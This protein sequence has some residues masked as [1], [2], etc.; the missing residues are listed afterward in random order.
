MTRRTC[1][2]LW[3]VGVLTG[4]QAALAAPA[5]PEVRHYDLRLELFPETGRIEGDARITI[6]N[7]GPTPLTRVPFVLYRLFV[8][9]AVSDADDAP[10]AHE[11]SVRRFEDNER[12]Q[13]L[14]AGVTLRRPLDPGDSAVIRLRYAGPFLGAGEVWPYL[15]DRVSEEYS[16]IRPDAAGYPIVSGLDRL[17]VGPSR[18]FTAAVE[19]S[20]PDRFMVAGGG[21]RLPPM[22]D[23]GRTRHRFVV[24]SPTWRLDI[25]AAPFRMLHATGPG[26]T[27]HYLGA[28]S[29]AAN[30][31]LHAAHTATLTLRSWFGPPPADGG[32]TIIEVPEGWG[33]QAGDGYLL[34][35]GG[36]FR[37]PA[38]LPEVYHEVAHGWNAPARP[39]QQAARWFDE[40]F[41]S[42]FQALVMG[43]V[44]GVAARD[45]QMTR[46]RESFRRAVARDPAHGDTPIARY[47]EAGLGGLSYTKGAWSLHVL[48][49]ALGDTGFRHFIRTLLN[50]PP[51]G[52]A[53]FEHVV[54]LAEETLGD[55]ARR[56]A[57]DWLIGTMSSTLLVGPTSA[58]DLANRYR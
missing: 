52:G 25:A 56:W 4:G 43:D 12:H 45:S 32:F 16:L 57:E 49:L 14:A 50:D 54:R 1:A 36:A 35:A 20:V 22:H 18:R 33:S 46:Y 21:E 34:Q 30:R 31:V 11:Q 26:I 9:T 6:R 19:V 53:T 44:S 7:P 42:Y 15:Q 13:V 27:V 41:A 28:D 39:D 3:C 48:H 29:T 10:L 8:I 58:T 37:D 38:R 5:L 23:A 17:A 47:G 55:G 2:L 51:T 24:R 40:A